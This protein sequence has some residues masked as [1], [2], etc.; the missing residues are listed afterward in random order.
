MTKKYK[1]RMICWHC[2]E[3]MIWGADFDYEDYGLEGEG[4]VSSFSCSNCPAVGEIYL[5]FGN[6]K[7]NI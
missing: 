6:E 2:G 5:T 4:I 1:E 3:P 7:E